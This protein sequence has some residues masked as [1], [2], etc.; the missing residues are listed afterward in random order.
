M[1]VLETLNM[2]CYYQIEYKSMTCE[3]SQETNSHTNSDVSLIFGSMDKI[4]SCK[5]IF[6]PAAVLNVT[7]RMRNY[8][9]GRQIWSKPHTVVLYDA[10]K[11][12]QPVL[13]VH[14]STEDSVV[15]SWRSS[16]DGSCRLRYRVNNTHTWTKAIDS[17]PVHQHQTLTYVIKDLLPFTA[18]RAAVACREH[19]GIWSDWSSDVSARTLD[20]V[21]S[22]PPE[23]CYRVEKNDSGGS[24]LL[25]LMWKDLD[26]RDAGG[27]IL[28]Y[29]VSYKP[30]KKQQ[31]QDRLLQNVTEVMALLVVKEGNYSVKVSAFNMA[32]YGPAARLS[33]DTLRLNTLPSVRNLWVSSSFPAM[34][35]LLIQWENP[36]SVLPVS[37]FAVQWQPETRPSFSR[38]TTVDSFTTSTVIQDVDPDESYLI[39]V[40][41]VYNQQCGPA[42][43][44]PASL[45]QGALMEAINLNVVGVTKT[46]VTVG[47]AWRKA[48]GPIRVN[49]YSVLL[50]KDTERLTA[51]SLWPDQQ[52][53]KLLNLKPNTEYALL[54]LADNVSRNIIFVRTHFDEVPVVATAT[55]LLLLAVTVFVISILS[56]TVYKSY[57]FPLI[58][59][60]QSSTTGKWLMDPN[61]QKTAERN[62]LNIEDFQVADIL[63]ERSPIIVRPN[64]QPSSEEDLHEDTSVLL[65]S[66][67]IVRLSTLELDTEYVS[68]APIT[69]E[70]Q[71]ACAQSSCHPDYTVNCC[72]P[73]TVFISEE[74]RE[75]DA[76]LLHQTHEANSWFPQKESRQADFSE[77]SHQKLTAVKC[78]FRE[79]T[80]NTNSRCACQMTC[81]AEYEVNSSFLGKKD[82]ETVSRQSNCS[83]LIC[84][85]TYVANSLFTEKPADRTTNFSTPCSVNGTDGKIRR[86]YS[87][88]SFRRDEMSKNNNCVR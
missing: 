67:L 8:I 63:G 54:L 58:S 6:N 17:V 1:P 69:T 40:I 31:L 7:A 47:W 43:S 84:E 15:V 14:G 85:P 57:F 12:S 49:R 78:C 82:V 64:S 41:P 32:G 3:W 28:G 73:D 61:H 68:D 46:T 38:W 2:S 83:Y 72:H 23:V 70:H 66:H 55:P 60:P 21:P 51:L 77:T 5:A 53:H 74:S 52:Q 62:I 19:S 48:S 37:H 42:Q 33:I 9:M 20:R 22:R 16:D 75:A 80:A 76:A 44:L 24:L 86:G 39:R 4:I 11:P 30:E 29:Q 34:K 10:V 18:Y 45:Q 81:E 50:K 79:L 27:H 56:R 26:L 36:P 59:N 35:G 71:L 65:I 13:T 25:H 88:T 87:P